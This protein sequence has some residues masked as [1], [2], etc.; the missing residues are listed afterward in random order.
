[1]ASCFIPD[2]AIEHISQIYGAVS[3][4]PP[5]KLSIRRALQAYRGGATLELIA[6]RTEGQS[7]DGAENQG[8]G[9]EEVPEVV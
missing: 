1:M 7:G 8:S 9:T 2:S 5:P 4:P 3:T 6:S